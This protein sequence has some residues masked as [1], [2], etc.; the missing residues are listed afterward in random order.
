MN[1]HKV[2]VL[3]L[4]FLLQLFYQL[5]IL[6]LGFLFTFSFL[7]CPCVPLCARLHLK[8]PWLTC[9]IVADSRLFVETIEKEQFISF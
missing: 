2:A 8:H 7:F 1:V 4:I 9:I 6:F 3:F 5:D